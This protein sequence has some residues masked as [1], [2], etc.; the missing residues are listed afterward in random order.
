M[1][2]P[3]WN[4]IQKYRPFSELI[5]RPLCLYDIWDSLPAALV[6]VQNLIA[7]LIKR[8]DTW[9]SRSN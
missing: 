4:K 5:K 8:R 9:K 1:H 6:A 3:Q 2:A 7:S